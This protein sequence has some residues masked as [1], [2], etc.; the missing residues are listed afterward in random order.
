[1][2]TSGAVATA[3]PKTPAQRV[4]E[5]TSDVSY[6]EFQVSDL[7][8]RESKLNLDLGR[9]RTMRDTSFGGVTM[10]QQW[11]DLMLWEAVLNSTPELRGV[12]EI[13]TWKGGFSW[14]LWAQTRAR[15]I[16][17]KTYDSIAPDN[18]PPGFERLDVF[19]Y[20]ERVEVAIRG[21]GEPIMVFCDGGNKPR[22]LRTFAPMLKDAQSVIAVHDWGSE[23]MPSDIPDTLV[24]VFGSYCDDLGSITRF[25]RAAP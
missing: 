1:M 18:P 23:I 15:Q 7:K 3:A 5:L 24:E 9:F 20:P 25:F 22:E 13:G 14:W 12:I 6:L 17:F 10:A 11:S 4:I 16:G 19:A 8:A 21:F 2:V